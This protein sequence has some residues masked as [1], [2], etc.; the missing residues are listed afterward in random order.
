MN[1]AES[2]YFNTALLMNQAL[3]ELLNKKE[4]DY[5]TI[6][7]ICAKAGVNRSTF[8]LHYETIADLLEECIQN[9]NKQFQEYFS[10]SSHEFFDKLKTADKDDL[11]LVTPE[12]LTPYLNYIKNNKILYAV[13]MKHH[14]LMNSAQ[15]FNALNRHVFMPIFSKFGVDEKSANYMIA[16][17]INGISA[18]VSQW[19]KNDCQDDISYIENLIIKCVRPFLHS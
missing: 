9:S 17:Y 5:I 3:I 10:Q 12:Y 19:I 4:Y 2:K 1:K 18:I 14:V 11:I 16:Y 8:Y 15:K 7:E 13:S 6:K